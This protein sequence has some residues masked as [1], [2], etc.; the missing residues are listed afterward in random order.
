MAKLKSNEIV[1][2]I[3]ML[4]KSSWFWCAE[5]TKKSEELKLAA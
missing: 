5:L 3:S 2:D 1:T 4:A